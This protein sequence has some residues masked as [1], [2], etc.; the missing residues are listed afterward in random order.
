MKDYTLSQQ[1]ALIGLDG[2]DA[3]HP[4]MAKTMVVRG[5][6]AARLLE[7]CCLSE[8]EPVETTLQTGLKDIAGMNKKE[9][10]CLEEEVRELLEQDGALEKAPDILACDMN[11]ATAGVEIMAYRTN[12]DIY[13]RLAEGIRAEVLEEGPITREA[14]C[15]LW[16]MRESGCLHDVFSVEEQTRL[17]AR[18]VELSA[19]VPLYQAIWQAEFHN[20]LES[21]AGNFLRAK[22]NLFKNP[23][24]EGVNL[25]FPFLDRRKSIF[26]DFVVLGTDV[27]S[28]RLAVLSYLSEQGHYVQEVKYGDETLLKVDNVYYRIFPMTKVCYRIPIQGANLVPVYL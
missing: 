28:R 10:G 27:K 3:I 23:Y 6:A 12:A 16:L 7:T 19:A 1:F 15:L 9:L 20:S 24:M 5:V 25:L 22:K 26:I 13:T 8:G 14:F 17:N 18:M 2:L 21:L 11:Y 4:S